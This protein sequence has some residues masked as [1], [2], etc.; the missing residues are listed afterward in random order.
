MNN[1]STPNS[2]ADLPRIPSSSD[3]NP[4]EAASPREPQDARP[5]AQKR[6]Q[7]QTKKKYEFINGLMNN[8]D[9]LIYVELCITYYM[10]CSLFR[11]L[12][13]VLSQMMFLTPKPSFIPPMP[14]HRPYIGAIFGPNSICL[15]LHMLTAR[16]EAGEA[17]RGYLHGGIIVDLIGQK[18]P[19]SKFHLVFLDLLVTGLQCVMLAVHVERERLS[20]IMK[21]DGS[22]AAVPAS[23]Q[24]R[25]DLIT[26]QDHD[27]EERGVMRD[28][29]VS[30]GDIAMQPLASGASGPSQNS[31]IDADMERPELLEAQPLGDETEDDDFALD[32]CWSGTAIVADFHVL[33]TLHTQ[34]DDYGNATASALQTVGFNA[35]FAAVTTNRHLNAASQ[36]FHRAL[37]M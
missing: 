3:S 33:H 19:T 13:R 37:T 15:L 20:A 1:D 25:A 9:T 6:I 27:A 22:P 32:A 7:A 17:M 23:G 26:T 30:T 12:I 18:G 10:D 11:L 24:P 4:A 14:K 29:V 34:W 5:P 28:A 36:R 16:S 21:S 2:A 31:E 35:E 8:L